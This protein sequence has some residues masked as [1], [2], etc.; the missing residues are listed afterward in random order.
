M[1]NLQEPA[2]YRLCEQLKEQLSEYVSENAARLLHLRVDEIEIRL[3][4]FSN[5]NLPL[6][7]SEGASMA[8]TPVRTR[9]LTL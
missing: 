4:M 1:N 5:E 3:R 2:V 9:S 8:A 7:C 6:N